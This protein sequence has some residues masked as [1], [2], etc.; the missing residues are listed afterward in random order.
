MKRLINLRRK[1][2]KRILSGRALN[3]KAHRRFAFESH[4]EWIRFR[5]A[6]GTKEEWLREV[7][8]RP[9]RTIVDREDL[10]AI[11]EGPEGSDSP[12]IVKSSPQQT[13]QFS[14]SGH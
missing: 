9:I 8:S 12:F 14:H 4:M 10:F 7:W 3:F 6:G 2:R 5:N 13:V 1:N 11:F